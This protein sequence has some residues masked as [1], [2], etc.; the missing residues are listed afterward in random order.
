MSERERGL[1]AAWVRMLGAVRAAAEL[2]EERRTVMSVAVGCARGTTERRVAEAWR[3]W[4]G[5]YGDT[6]SAAAP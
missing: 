6:E 2:G 5:L 3:A 4:L 1:F